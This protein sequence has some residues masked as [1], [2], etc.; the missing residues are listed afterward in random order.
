MSPRFHCFARSLASAYCEHYSRVYT[1]LITYINY[2]PAKFWAVHNRKQKSAGGFP[3]G[4]LFYNLFLPFP[5]LWEGG[6]QGGWVSNYILLC[7]LTEVFKSVY[8]SFNMLSLLCGTVS[9]V[10]KGFA[11]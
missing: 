3:C 6:I 7:I 4:L 5:D 10:I 9:Q 8:Y 1:K 11:D 2:K